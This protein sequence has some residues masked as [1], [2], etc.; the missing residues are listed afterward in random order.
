MKFKLR[1]MAT[2]AVI[3]LCTVA[4]HCP[5]SGPDLTNP[6]LLVQ[7]LQSKG[8]I[9]VDM[10]REILDVGAIVS[11]SDSEGIRYRGDIKDCGVPK[12]VVEVRKGAT[13]LNGIYGTE[14]GIDLKG[15]LSYQNVT[16]G[17]QA[18]KIAHVGFSISDTE[19]SAMSEIK[20]KRWLEENRSKLDAVCLD[21][22]I[23]KT[24]KE[25]EN[26]KDKV[27][28]L[29]DVLGV[30]KFSYT[31][32]DK[33]GAKI[34]LTPEI[35]KDYVQL[36]ANGRVTEDGKLSFDSQRTLFIAFKKGIFYE[37][38]TVMGATATTD[39]NIEL[40]QKRRNGVILQDVK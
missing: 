39:K 40:I 3:F 2:F 30:K 26:L 29:V 1:I 6:S 27:W 5:H 28:I 32:Y 10:P 20:L 34:T 31:F 17:A 14:Y 25:N 24:P 12:E 9:Y 19:E 33:S 16:I 23:G 13:G 18:D 7:S 11:I 21:Y 4:A 38:G 36:E 15:L 37:S 22:L 35:V 8:W